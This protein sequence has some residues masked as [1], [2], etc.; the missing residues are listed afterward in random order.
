MPLR[1]TAVPHVNA[2]EVMPAGK[3]AKIREL[4]QRPGAGGVAMVGDG[5]NDS[6][7]LAQAGAAL[8]VVWRLPRLLWY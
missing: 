6:P 4:Q 5:V 2:A 8:V 3:V 1:S 7:A